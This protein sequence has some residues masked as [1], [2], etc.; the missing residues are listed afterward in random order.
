MTKK[1]DKPVVPDAT[2]LTEENLEKVSGGFYGEPIEIKPPSEN[3]PT[4][5]GVEPPPF[6]FILIQN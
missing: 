6:I 5:E 4:G 2:E 3:P 1:N